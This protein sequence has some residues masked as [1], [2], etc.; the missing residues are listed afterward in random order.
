MIS[1]GSEISSL[2]RSGAARRKE[3]SFDG[4][5]LSSSGDADSLLESNSFLSP[6]DFALKGGHGG[7]VLLELV[8]A[9]LHRTVLLQQC[10]GIGFLLGINLFGNCF[11]IV[12]W[13]WIRYRHGRPERKRLGLGG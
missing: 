12:G 8:K 9:L 11:R 5:A 7:L 6:F 4:F 1:P 13:R 10:L 3:K 2:A